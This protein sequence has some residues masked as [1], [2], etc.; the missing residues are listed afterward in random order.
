MAIRKINTMR[1]AGDVI[2]QEAS[3]KQMQ[4]EKIQLSV[5]SSD[6]N[7]PSPFQLGSDP[8]GS[9]GDNETVLIF[10]VQTDQAEDGGTRRREKE[11]RPQ[12]QNCLANIQ[13]S[14]RGSIWATSCDWKCLQQGYRG[15]QR[16]IVLST[17]KWTSRHPGG[18]LSLWLFHHFPSCNI[19]T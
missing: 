17:A 1:S 14:R 5:S 7:K 19:H 4:L 10:S 16:H 3:V 15:A 6:P 13:T 2:K 9:W 11:G 12:G 18:S 8:R